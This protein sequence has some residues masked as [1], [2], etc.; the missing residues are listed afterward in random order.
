MEENKFKKLISRYAKGEANETESALIEAWY[1]SYQSQESDV[2]VNQNEKERSKKELK[3]LIHGSDGKKATYYRLVA[4]VV[5]I[6]SAGAIFYHW[7]SKRPDVYAVSTTHVGQIKKI[8]LPD[9][10]IAWLNASS[11]LRVQLNFEGDK[12]EVYL[13]EGE[14]FFKVQKNPQKPFLVHAGKLDVRVLGTSFNVRSYKHIHSM[15]V[16][17]ATGRVQVDEGKKNLAVLIAKQELIYNTIT[18]EFKQ[19]IVDPDE[20][21]GWREGKIYLHQVDFKELQL[22]LKNNFHINIEAGDKSVNAYRFT[23]KLSA[24]MTKNQILK[25]VSAIHN[26]K[27]RKEGNDMILY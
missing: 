13:D 20:V 25:I 3:S 23:L 9:N 15:K 16:T 14:A 4:A 5:I 27:Y 7:R 12:R 19:S 11:K 8:I 2:K 22:V 17:V 24:D 26:S 10:S 6:C 21:K 1:K 18:K